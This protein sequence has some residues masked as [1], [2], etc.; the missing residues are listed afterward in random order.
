MMYLET[1]LYARCAVLWQNR[2]LPSVCFSTS[3]VRTRAIDNSQY[4]GPSATQLAHLFVLTVVNSLTLFALILLL[5]RTIWSLSLNMT[6]I[7]GWEVERHEVVLRRARTL[8]GY[9]DGPDGRRVKIERQEFPWDIGIW[10]NLCQ[11]MGT[12]NLLAWLWPFASSTSVE[13]GLA[14]EHNEIDGTASPP[15]IP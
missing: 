2:H 6:T 14:F 13:S 9:V 5:G 7:E 1:L 15:F 10:S 12:K 8:G 3:P 11:S 4:L